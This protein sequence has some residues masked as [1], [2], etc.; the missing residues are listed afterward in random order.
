MRNAAQDISTMLSLLDATT[1]HSFSLIRT[2]ERVL[3]I[4]NPW[5]YGVTGVFTFFVFVSLPSLEVPLLYTIALAI[6]FYSAL[7]WSFFFLR[8][9]KQ[10][11][12]ELVGI[13]GETDQYVQS[14]L[15]E[16]EVVEGKDPLERFLNQL[17]TADPDLDQI[18]EE[19]PTQLGKNVDLSTKKSKISVDLYLEDHV[20]KINRAKV[21]WAIKRY[22]RGG[23]VPLDEIAH[24]KEGIE[25]YGN[26][27]IG[28]YRFLSWPKRTLRDLYVWVVST[29]G[30]SAEVIKYVED[31]ENWIEI[32]GDSD[33]ESDYV[34]LN[35]VRENS[36]NTYS[37]ISMP[38]LKTLRDSRLIMEKE[39][40][41]ADLA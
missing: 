16:T 13:A 24:L 39:E 23:V 19:K 5:M 15:I 22:D 14:V 2:I 6:V 3:V 31:E 34:P 28:P 18:L 4:H 17:R 30:F 37:I 35:L 11:K 40:D 25:A 27:T 8:R 33:D 1:A 29:Y 38:Y 9:L 26:E 32:S 36:D 10:G 41:G 21:A 20:S 7:V 12:N